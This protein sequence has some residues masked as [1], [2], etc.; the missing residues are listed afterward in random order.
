MRADPRLFESFVVL[1]DELHFG[2]AAARLHITQPTLSQQ[3][4]RLEDQLGVVL[5][6]RTRRHVE[7]TEAGVAVLPA[8]RVAVQGA[9][10][11]GEAA[12]A[13]ATGNH[14][15]LG[16]GF[17]PGAHHAVQIA[18]GVFNRDGDVRVRARQEPTTLLAEHISAGE[19]DVAVGFCTQP[20]PGVRT[21]SLLDEPAVVALRRDHPRAA[22]ET[23][24]LAELSRETFA[25][26]DDRDGAGYNRAVQR[27]CRHAGFEPRVAG[28]REG[29][30][31]W[32]TAVARGCV[33]VTTRSA[34]H[35]RARDLRVV[36]LSDA[37]TFT[38]ELL[39]SAVHQQRPA[40]MRFCETMRRL[41]VAGC[42]TRAD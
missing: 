31:A 6:A 8:A 29:P 5:F 9:I 17:S 33:G 24:E 41:A 23:L 28:A 25:L 20:E 21:E 30:M 4:K 32:E 36:P 1:A 26:V 13:H 37:A 11:A 38:L 16:L 19:L 39:S 42:L 27:M 10:A 7:L 18:L 34:A 40:I 15:E 14:G 35:A 22:A 3:V 12:T 2:R